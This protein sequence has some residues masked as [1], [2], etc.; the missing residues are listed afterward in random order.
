MGGG[1]PNDDVIMPSR[2]RRAWPKEVLNGQTKQRYIAL[3]DETNKGA[4]Q[5]R[6]RAAM[7]WSCAN[8]VWGGRGSSVCNH[9]KDEN[10]SLT[11]SP[12]PS[13]QVVR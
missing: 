9:I 13:E 12:H 2:L 1:G 5:R 8:A 10:N 7:L 11:H 6:G 3:S 4:Y